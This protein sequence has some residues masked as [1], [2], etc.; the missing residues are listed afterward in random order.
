MFR[1]FKARAVLCAISAACCGLASTT[2]AAA[3]PD[4]PIT[5]IVS[6]QAGG[7]ADVIARALG[8]QLNASLKQP[9]IVENRPGAYTTLGLAQ[10]AKAKP[11]GY[12]LGIMFMPHTVLSTLYKG[13]PYDVR[14]SFTPISKAAD[15]FNVLVVNKDV[16]AKSVPELVAYIKS[17]PGQINYGSGGTGTPA[18]L[19]GEFFKRQAGV[20]MQHIPFKGPADALTNVIGGRVDLMFLS[21][22]VAMPMVKGGKL[23]ALATTGDRRAPAALD[24]PTMT[25]S[26]YKDFVVLDWMGVVGPAGMPADLVD[27]LNKEI[28]RAVADPELRSKLQ[29]LGMEPA[30]STST[31]FGALIASE[32]GKWEKFSKQVGITL[33]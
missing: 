21:L 18:H 5:I 7:P 20:D 15:L 30:A 22:P 14:K 8:Q 28:A 1:A 31:D 17:K 24:V 12:T 2:A 29:P 4:K 33:D 26:G 25:Q 19:S 9:V 6:D 23:N 10:V 32:V 16:P 27:L 11:D 13:T 3:Y